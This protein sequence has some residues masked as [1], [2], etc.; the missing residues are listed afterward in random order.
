MHILDRG[1]I[2]DATTAPHAARF[3][4]FTS[5]MPQMLQVPGSAFTSFGCI[6][7][8]YPLV[9]VGISFSSGRPVPGIISCAATAVTSTHA[10]ANPMNR[11]T[12]VYPPRGQSG[13]NSAK[14]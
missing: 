4:T 1:T 5:V 13:R 6:G 10:S 2:F 9:V 12:L 3:C 7:Q 14:R 8:M 11:I